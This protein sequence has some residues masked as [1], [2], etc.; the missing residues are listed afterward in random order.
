MIYSTDMIFSPEHNQN[1]HNGNSNASRIPITEGFNVAWLEKSHL[2]IFESLIDIFENDN[3]RY[4][5]GNEAKRLHEEAEFLDISLNDTPLI[6][7]W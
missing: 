6:M 2:D 7:N 1:N 4:P 5:I 3:G